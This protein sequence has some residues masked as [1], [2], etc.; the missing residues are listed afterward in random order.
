MMPVL[1]TLRVKNNIL[2]MSDAIKHKIPENVPFPGG[3]KT[4]STN[5]EVKVE[6]SGKEVKVADPNVQNDGDNV[7]N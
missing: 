5:D 2:K 4:F 1:K 6:E 3:L 7:E